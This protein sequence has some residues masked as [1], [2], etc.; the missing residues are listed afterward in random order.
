MKKVKKHY[1]LFI[2]KVH[3]QSVNTAEYTPT[4]HICWGKKKT[5]TKPNPNQ[6][7]WQTDVSPYTFW[8][9]Y[10]T[11]CLYQVEWPWQRANSI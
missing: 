6:N 1:I 11:Y 5:K 7:T 8:G 2:A 9:S 10:C 3:M 4:K